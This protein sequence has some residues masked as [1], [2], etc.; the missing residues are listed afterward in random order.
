MSVYTELRHNIKTRFSEALLAARAAGELDFAAVPPFVL[1]EPRERAHGDLAVNAAL[2]LAKETRRPPREVAAVLLRHLRPEGV[3]IA[4]TEVAGPGFINIHLD[5]AWLGGVLPEILT[6]GPRYGASDMGRGQ[7]VQVE[8]VSANPTGLLHMGNARGAALG[9]S[10]AALLAFTGCEVEREFYLNDTGNQINTLALSLEARYFQL[11]GREGLVPEN[12]Y[13]GEDVTDTMRELVARDGAMYLDMEA[14]ARRE[15]LTAYAL[16]AKTAAMRRVLA[17]FG[18]RYDIW[19]SEKSLHTSGYVRE[20]L[21]VLAAGGHIYERDGAVW[22]KGLAL[23][24][25]K[26]EV[27]IRSDGTPTYFAADIAYHRH[28]F[29]RGF[30]RVI[31]IWGADHHGHVARMQAAL[32]ALGLPPQSLRVILMQFVRLIEGGEVVKMS[33]RTGRYITLH[34]L[35]TDVGRDAARFFFLLRAPDSTVDFDLD[36]AKKES[37]ENPV[38]YVQYAHARLCSIIRHAQAMGLDIEQTPAASVCALLS[39]TQETALLRCLAF[40]PE[41]VERAARLAEPHRL[42]AYVLELAGLYHSFYNHC[43]VLQA[44]TEDLRAARV[45]LVRG[46]RFVLAAALGILGVTAPESM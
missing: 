31:N 23:G 4:G 41:E 10:L 36:L 18:V 13:H 29:A 40:W 11:L 43:R 44:E 45:A 32:G 3:W 7:K 5:P 16:T 14:A 15:A 42:T 46:T 1:E 25:E 20:T 28:K 19:F 34:D 6:A 21:D 37:A 12:G 35:L 39:T 9:D 24:E 22:L 33:K 27:M 30:T 8:F 38:F 17:D 26:D 2:L